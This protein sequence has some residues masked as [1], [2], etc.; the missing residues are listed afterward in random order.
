[1]P[2]LAILEAVVT[3]RINVNS[4]LPGTGISHDH[5]SGVRVYDRCANLV[6]KSTMETTQLMPMIPVGD[7]RPVGKVSPYS[8]EMELIK[9]R[10]SSV[11][12]LY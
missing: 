5:K 2:D 3:V 6:W 12:E 9:A 8:I 4:Y 10:V 1:M 7:L 11:D